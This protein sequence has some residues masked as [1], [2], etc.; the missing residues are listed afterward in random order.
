MKGAKPLSDG[1]L[2]TPPNFK[3]AVYR[4]GDVPCIESAKRT[5]S[6]LCASA[7]RVFC[8]GARRGVVDT[9][10]RGTRAGVA[11]PYLLDAGD[12]VRGQQTC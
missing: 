10:Y 1:W 6:Y 11:L 12:P 9:S 8:S 5:A 7:A 2:S 4:R 3:M